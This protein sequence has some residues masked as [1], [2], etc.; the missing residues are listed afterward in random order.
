MSG[1]TDD[2]LNVKPEF[3]QNTVEIASD[4]FMSLD[5][6]EIQF[7]QLVARLIHNCQSLGLLICGAGSHPFCQRLAT[8]TPNPRYLH[9]GEQ[10][11]YLA[12]NQIT[13]ATHVHLGMT[14]GS[15]ALFAMR[16]LKPYLPLLIGLS[17]NSPFW[18]GYNTGFASYRHR[19]LA[20]SKSYGIPPSFNNWRDFE[21]FFEQMRNAGIFE[22]INDIHWDIRPR[23]KLGTL[24]IRVM[25]VQPTVHQS[26]ALARF[27]RTLVTYLL[28]KNPYQQPDELPQTEH[29]WIE[30]DNYFQA[31]REGLEANYVFDKNGKI[32]TL[33]EIF[34]RLMEA[35]IP[36]APKHHS[37]EM[38]TWATGLITDGPPY[39][40][41]QAIFQET[42]SLSAVSRRLVEQ[43]ATE[44]MSG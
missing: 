24:E 15:Q 19:I 41:Q 28:E 11:G 20:A 34:H 33:S 8:I 16:Q 44:V 7:R 37:A 22:S 32:K 9:L 26:I 12:K 23:P 35:I 10:Q 38:L 30:K 2:G 21:R 27:L 25:D 17:A 14:S 6:M 3:I 43:L 18:R 13:F 40:M 4:V 39:K 31:S 42:N 36:Y 29:W 5:E 1:F